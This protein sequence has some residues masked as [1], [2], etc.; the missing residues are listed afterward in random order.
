[1]A[2]EVAMFIHFK[3][4][5]IPDSIESIILKQLRIQY[6]QVANKFDGATECFINVD[7]NKLVFNISQTA[8]D[9]YKES[10]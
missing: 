6:E 2:F 5:A 3:D 8:C 4:G 9:L 1:M 7:Y 10:Y